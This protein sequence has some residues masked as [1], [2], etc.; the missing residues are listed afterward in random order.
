MVADRFTECIHGATMMPD[1]IA[2]CIHG[3]T[4]G[5]GT[6]VVPYHKIAMVPHHGVTTKCG[7]AWCGQW[8]TQVSD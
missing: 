4:M 1:T 7:A 3:A 6:T 5:P 2:E 8:V